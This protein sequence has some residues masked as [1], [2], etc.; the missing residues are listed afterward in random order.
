MKASY[1]PEIAPSPGFSS[2]LRLAESVAREAGH[3]LLSHFRSPQLETTTKRYLD[4]VTQADTQSEALV[5]S[6]LKDAFP[7]DAILGEE[8][9]NSDSRNR[10][11]WYIDPLDGTYN[12]SRGL[13]FWCV[14]IGLVSDM[15]SVVGV[16]FDPLMDE[17]FTSAVG[18]GSFVNGRPLRS[19]GVTEPASRRPFNSR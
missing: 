8:G 9:T 3:L 17:M 13:P 11:A 12:F 15:T 1:D 14:S 7:D 18:M 5:A 16:V 10:R 19:S 4:V 2:E 6:R